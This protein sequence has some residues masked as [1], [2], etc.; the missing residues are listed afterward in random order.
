VSGAGVDPAERARVL[1]LR[2]DELLASGG[3]ESLDEALLA[4][5]GGL[6]VA[7]EPGVDDEELPRLFEQ[8]IATVRSRLEG[9][10]EEEEEEEEGQGS[11][12]RGA[13][14]GEGGRGAEGGRGGRGAER[15]RDA[16]GGGE[17][18][19][20]GPEHGGNNR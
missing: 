8:R 11:R 16:T 20:T 9:G 17:M 19:G 5:Q 4:Y 18:G 6:E 12:D 7:R 15:R 3:P 14:G 10:L 2:G 13:E 1:L